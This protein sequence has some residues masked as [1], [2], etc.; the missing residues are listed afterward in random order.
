MNDIHHNADLPGWTPK[1]A[2]RVYACSVCGTETTIST[3]H[4][5]TVAATPCA[6]SCKDISN[7]H[8]A[9]ERVFWH[10]PRLHRYVR[11]AGE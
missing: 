4:T 11:D 6:G 7:P 2:N 5:G 8:T 1:V 3:N 9:R 10:A